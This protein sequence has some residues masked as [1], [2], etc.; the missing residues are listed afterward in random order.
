MHILSYARYTNKDY[1]EH[2]MARL[3]H[4]SLITLALL[5]LIGCG[6]DSS[7]STKKDSETNTENTLTVQEATDIAVEAYIY[8]YSLITT[9]VTRVQFTN[10]AT[11]NE[12]P[13][14]APMGQLYNVKRYPPADYRGVSSPNADTLYSV[15]WVDVGNEPWI[16]SHPDMGDRF[17]LFPIY[18]MWMPVIDSPGS[19]TAGGAAA[20]Y[21][22]TGPNWQ[23]TLPDG[24][25]EIKSPTKYALILGRTYSTGT[26]QDYAAV[27]NLQE[28]YKLYPLSSYGATYTAPAQSPVNNNVGFSM[29]DKPQPVINAMDITTYFNMMTELMAEVAPPAAEDTPQL[30]RM[31]KLGIIPGKPFDPTKLSPEIQQALGDVNKIAMERINVEVS[32]NLGVIQNGWRIPT[33]TGEYG[34]DYLTR[35]AVAAFGWPANLAADAIYPFTSVDSNGEILVGTN[36]YTLHFAADQMPPVKGFWSITMY[37]SDQGFWFYP[38]PLNKFTESMRDKP[39]LNADGSL[40]LYFQN[41]SPGVDKEANWLPAPTGEFVLMMRLYWP[42]ETNPSILPPGKGSWVIPAVMK[43]EPLTD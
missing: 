25:T 13:M 29:T 24:V 16:F 17:Y 1:P 12:K 20:T 4:F 41:E 43:M 8:G 27:N 31:A 34:T 7:S 30:Q 39:K 40:D 2:S 6:E 19:R 33:A 23:G 18:S 11:A 32:K 28:Q 21:A 10:V 14:H 38:N 22:I 35:A 5:G 26:D 36:K 15:A 42:T 9:E 3:L 37:T